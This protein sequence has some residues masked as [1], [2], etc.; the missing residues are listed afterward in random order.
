MRALPILGLALLSASCGPQTLTL[1]ADPVDRAATCGVVAAAAARSGTEMKAALPFAA[2]SRIVHHALLA[3]AAG[4]DGFDAE[5]AGAV[6]AR[7]SALQE[8]IVAGKWQ[9]LVPACNAAFPAVTRTDITLPA[10]RF[11]AQLGCDELAGFL[12][13]ALAGEDSA[14][15]EELGKLAGL[16][17]ALDPQIAP[18]LRSRAGTALDAQQA[19]RRKA[20]ASIAQAGSPAAV[21]ER[22]QA[23]FDPAE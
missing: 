14:Y 8:D 18:G 2:Q 15:G 9:D 5:R 3:G 7:M 22:C 19:L 20:L 21:I 16:T 1:P 10:G 23:R 17:R 4:A 11:E 13:K 6:S 12:T